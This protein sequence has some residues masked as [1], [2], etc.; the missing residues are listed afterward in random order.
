MAFD[1]VQ[2]D[3]IAK[4]KDL[5]ENLDIEDHVAALSARIAPLK[6]DFEE[7]M[8]AC[9]KTCWAL[10]PDHADADSTDELVGMLEG[11][12]DRLQL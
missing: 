4:G 11:S 1:A 10:Y 6:K 8:T 2:A 9:V 3:R 7:V 5:A 12:K